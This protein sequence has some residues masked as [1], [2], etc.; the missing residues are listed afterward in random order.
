MVKQRLRLE[1]FIVAPIAGALIVAALWLSISGALADMR[2]A[3]FISQIYTVVSTARDMKV[4]IRADASQATDW[5]WDHLSE[6][7]E[8]SGGVKTAHTIKNPWT[9]DIKLGVIPVTQQLWI[10]ATLP[11]TVCYP[12]L[13]FVDKNKAVIGVR[14]ILLREATSIIDWRQLYEGPDPQKGVIDPH[15]IQ[16]WCLDRKR[17][18]VLGLLLQLQ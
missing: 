7:G 4:D 9:E 10:E 5:L 13:S 11:A 14:R 18:M 17:P 6:M 3:R 12:T 16:A 8:A 1:I 2:F 15:A